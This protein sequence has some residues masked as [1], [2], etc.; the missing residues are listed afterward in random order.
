M[1]QFD[2]LFGKHDKVNHE[3]DVFTA[4]VTARDRRGAWL[5]AVNLEKTWNQAD[6]KVVYTA[7][8][9]G[10]AGAYDDLVSQ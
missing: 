2:I 9:V 1:G 5:Q 7:R 3:I 6:R 10:P 4:T 8:Q